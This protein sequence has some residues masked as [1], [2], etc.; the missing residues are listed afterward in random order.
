MSHRLRP[1]AHRV[2][3]EVILQPLPQVLSDRRLVGALSELLE[4][5]GE[6][7]V[8]LVLHVVGDAERI[9]LVEQTAKAVRGGVRCTAFVPCVGSG[10]VA[11]PASPARAFR[12]C[13]TLTVPVSGRP[14][15]SHAA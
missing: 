11:Q 3:T 14:A 6:H 13:S 8:V 12:S 7:A 15:L 10:V 4:Q 9:P 1:Q 2:Y 5:Q